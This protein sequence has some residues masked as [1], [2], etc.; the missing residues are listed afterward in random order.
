ME[1]RTSGETFA[2]NTVLEVP[3]GAAAAGKR[4]GLETS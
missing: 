4:R 1:L 3:A 2:V